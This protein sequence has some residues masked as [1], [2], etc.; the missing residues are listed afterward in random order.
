VRQ[1]LAALSVSLHAG[2]SVRMM[3]T[4]QFISSVGGAGAP[5]VNEEN[6]E[7]KTFAVFVIFCSKK[8]LFALFGSSRTGIFGF[9]SS[10]VIRHLPTMPHR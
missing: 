2:R 9:P 5:K 6:K 1:L 8:F 4:F 7:T 10:F 3:N